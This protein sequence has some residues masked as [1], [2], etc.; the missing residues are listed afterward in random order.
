MRPLRLGVVFVVVASVGGLVLPALGPAMAAPAD[1]VAISTTPC[2]PSITSV[3]AFQATAT[4]TVQIEGTCFGTG[5]TLNDSRNFYLQIEDVSGTHAWNACYLVDHP[6]VYCTVSSWTNDQITF[7]GFNANYGGSNTLEPG[8]QLVVAVWNPQTLIGPTTSQATVVGTP[9]RSPL[10]VPTITSVGQFQPGP[11]Q[12]VDIDGTCL[13]THAPFSQANKLD[14]YIQDS[15]SSPVAWSAC[16]SGAV[17]DIVRCTVSSWTN[18]Q[19]VLT[20]F[21]PGYGGQFVLEPGDQM[22]VTVWNHGTGAGPG[23]FVTTVGSG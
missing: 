11:T 17:N 19:I 10:C 18:T 3:G 4:Q 13:G 9:V 15:S 14:L 8:D 12:N 6:T 1:R 16:N 21:G 5:A 2:T 22:I 23:T 7:S 20:S